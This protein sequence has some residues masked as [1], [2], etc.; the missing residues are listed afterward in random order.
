VRETPVVIRLIQR[1]L[2]ADALRAFAQGHDV[3]PD[4][5][6]VLADRQ[7]D[8]LNE[9]GIDVLFLWGLHVFDA[10]LRAEH[11]AMAH[12]NQPSASV[13]PDNLRIESLWQGHPARLRGRACDLSARWLDLG[14]N[15]GPQCRGLLLDGFYQLLRH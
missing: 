7:V 2:L 15:V 14:P 13:F 11:Y 3:P 9:R 6:H 12:L 5:G 10:R 4:G 1:Q 8:A